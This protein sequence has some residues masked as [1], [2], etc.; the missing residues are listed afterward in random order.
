MEDLQQT[1]H[2]DGS[3]CQLIVS[4]IPGKANRDR[5]RNAYLLTGAAQLIAT[6]EPRFDDREARIL[7]ERFGF[8]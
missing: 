7:C 6:G 1:F 8:L 5:V 3:D 4:A 2:I